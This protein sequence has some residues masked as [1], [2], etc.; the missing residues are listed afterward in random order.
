MGASAEVRTNAYDVAKKKAYW[1]AGKRSCKP[2]D[3]TLENVLEVSLKRAAAAQRLGP[4][5][6]IATII[7]LTTFTQ[8][9]I[10]VKVWHS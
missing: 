7:E 2:R 1:H 10:I 6:C 9:L 4:F 5:D 8:G 3:G